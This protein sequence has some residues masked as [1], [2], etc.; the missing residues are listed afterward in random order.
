[1]QV[2]NLEVRF[3]ILRRVRYGGN[4]RY[5]S[6]TIVLLI[7][8]IAVVSQSGPVTRAGLV[9]DVVGT[10]AGSGKKSVEVILNDLNEFRG[11]VIAVDEDF[12]ILEPKKP[13]SA[14]K[15]TVISIGNVPN[16]STVRRIKYDDV[17]QIEGEKTTISFVPDP[18]A[19]PYATWN[20]VTSIGRGDF[21]QIH[22][23]S[24]GRIHGVFYRSTPDAL[25]LIRGNKEIVIP[26]AE[27][28][29]VY[30][31]KGDTRS[32]ATKI[33]AGGKIGTEISED[34]FPILDPRAMAHPIT[35]A[36]GAAIG[37]SLYVLSIG[38]TERLLVYSR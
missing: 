15:I 1:M 34:W 14:L 4:M 7:S 22:R 31:V 21:V 13:K 38:K 35:L 9:K 5:I 12:F 27:I 30:R 36:I 11:K 3:E 32:L 25:S 6:L 29:K 28:T 10:I 18:A 26:A 24:G 20:E 16:N 19:S 8:P 23:S 17:L 2:G 33:L 37:A